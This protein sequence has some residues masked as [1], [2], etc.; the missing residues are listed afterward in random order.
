[1][2][3]RYSRQQE[4]QDL[5]DSLRTG[6]EATGA[7][8]TAAEIAE[9][10]Y[11]SEAEKAAKLDAIKQHESLMIAEEEEYKKAEKEEKCLEIKKHNYPI[12]VRYLE[13]LEGALKAAREIKAGYGYVASYDVE[14]SLGRPQVEFELLIKKAK[15]GVRHLEQFKD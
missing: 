15:T 5:K 1:M 13:H 11:D 12:A 3:F 6:K 2:E 7:I 10:K 9:G 14:L 4:L 8:L